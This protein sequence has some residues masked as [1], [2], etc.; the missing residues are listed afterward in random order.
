M[1]AQP[2]YTVFFAY[3]NRE[4]EMHRSC[5]AGVTKKPGEILWDFHGWMQKEH[6]PSSYQVIRMEKGEPG[7]SRKEGRGGGVVYD[8]FANM[9]TPTV[10][11][12]KLKWK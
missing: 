4:E 7:I 8:E 6:T 11:G 12:G 10:E 9:K 2:H 5:N 3:N 1:K